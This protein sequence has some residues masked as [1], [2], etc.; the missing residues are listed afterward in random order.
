MR[1]EVTG[2]PNYGAG[3]QDWENVRGIPPTFVTHLYS[4]HGPVSL[5]DTA[6]TLPDLVGFWRMYYEKCLLQQQ[7]HLR[8]KI[9]VYIY[10]G[11]NS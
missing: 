6:P 8:N 3:T 11:C 5:A 1:H 7:Q 10:L 4:R 2:S 9:S